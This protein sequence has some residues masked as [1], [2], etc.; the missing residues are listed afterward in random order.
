MRAKSLA[1]GVIAIL[2]LTCGMA[3]Q[4]RP[5]V[6]WIIFVDDLH[7]DFRN[8]GRIRDMMKTIVSE[9]VHDGDRFAIVSS[10][11]STLA[12]DP[13]SD[14]QLLIDAIRKTTGNALRYEDIQSPNSAD[15]VKY[16]VSIAAA[17]AA[18]ILRN[19]SRVPGQK[20]LLFISNG[21]SFLPSDILGKL[22]G[23]TATAT[24]SGVRI[25]AIHPRA[26]FGDDPLQSFRDATWHCP[27]HAQITSLRSLA[28][29][30]GGFAI[31]DGYFDGQLRR[32]QRSCRSSASETMNP[33]P[34]QPPD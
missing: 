29:T 10:G 34:G 11:P 24:Q 12:V 13:T 4:S 1:S 30:T 27:R 31:V 32:Y 9:L 5:P 17:T 23:L 20:A 14:R 26:A 19:A 25:F 3:A 2:L 18:E 22:A 15:E 6:T 28:D 8:T 16:R 21:Y 33:N 7:L